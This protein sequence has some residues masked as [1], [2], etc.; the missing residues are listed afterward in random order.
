MLNVYLLLRLCNSRVLKYYTCVRTIIATGRFL[1]LASVDALHA[2]IL[3]HDL[4]NAL[5]WYSSRLCYIGSYVYHFESRHKAPCR[6]QV[7]LWLNRCM[8]CGI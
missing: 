6:L 5:E 7:L 3:V 8:I 1:G 4:R 2:T